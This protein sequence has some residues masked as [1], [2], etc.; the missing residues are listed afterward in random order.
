MHNELSFDRSLQ[1]Y[2]IKIIYYKNIT[3]ITFY[4]FKNKIKQ[5]NT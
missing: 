3:H 1:K 2:I 4:K 5:I